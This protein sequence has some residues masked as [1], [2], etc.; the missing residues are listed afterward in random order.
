MLFTISYEYNALVERL[1]ESIEQT[2]LVTTDTLVHEPNWLRLRFNLGIMLVPGFSG[3]QTVADVKTAVTRWLESKDFRGNVQVADLIDIVSAVGGVDNVRLLNSAEDA[4]EVNGV[5]VIGTAGTFRLRL[6][7]PK[8]VIEE[9]GTIAWNAANTAVQTA[10]EALASVVPGDVA[11]AARTGAGT[12]ADPYVWLITWQGR[13]ANRD[14][15]LDIDP[16]AVTGTGA[17]GS[18][19]E[20]VR[21]IGYGIQRVAENGLTVLET[22]TSDV[23][24]RSDQLPVIDASAGVQVDIKARNTF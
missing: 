9:T 5:R 10:L 17:G 13:W 23:Y 12:A 7:N 19:T 14:V 24:M 1:H 22:L 20:N 6:T 21:G 18:V 15:V 11:V 3:S 16:A 8:G 4:N 2:S